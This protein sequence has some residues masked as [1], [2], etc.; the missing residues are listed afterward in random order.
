MDAEV[1]RKFG[2]LESRHWWFGARRDIV[3]AI[4]ARFTPPGAR[5][6]DVGCGTGYFLER[7]R[8]RYQVSGADPSPIAIRMCAERGLTEISASDAAD[9]SQVAGKPF[10]VVTL[11]DVIEHLDD[12]VA[13]LNAAASALTEDGKVVVTVPAFQFLWTRHDDINHHRRRYTRVRLRSALEAAGFKVEQVSYFNSYLFPLALVER[14]GKRVLG[15]DRGA[16]LALPPAPINALMA[17]V[18][19]AERSRLAGGK[20]FPLGLS[21]LGVGRVSRPRQRPVTSPERSVTSLP[22]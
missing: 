21:V 14:L 9:L 6:L 4:V 11:L 5:L 1:F 19:R 7:A 16:D 13:A 15:L 12:D 8:E 22:A 3:L 18:F 2:E 17:R 10:D 20:G